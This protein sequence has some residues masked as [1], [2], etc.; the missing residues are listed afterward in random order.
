MALEVREPVLGERFI[1]GDVRVTTA[2]VKWRGKRGCFFA[3]PLGLLAARNVSSRWVA[4]FTRLFLVVVRAV[5]ELVVATA[6]IV[7][8]GL[9][10][11]AGALALTVGTMGLMAKACRR[12][13]QSLAPAMPKLVAGNIEAVLS[14][15]GEAVLSMRREEVPSAGVTK[16]QE[17]TH[18]S[19]G[20]GPHAHGHGF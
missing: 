11:V 5:P 14:V 15:P 20:N 7:A 12:Q 6:F 13:C 16:P 10:L 1:L 4:P 2:E 3:L 19:W 8:V 18:R 9:V 17:I